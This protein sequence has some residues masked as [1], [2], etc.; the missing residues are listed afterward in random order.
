LKERSNTFSDQDVRV[1]AH[2]IW[3]RNG[4]PEDQAEYHWRDALAELEAE[5]LAKDG[6]V[7]ALFQ[8]S[9]LPIH[10]EAALLLVAPGRNAA[11]KRHA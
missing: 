5:E 11:N 6:R 1:R 9:S 8:V 7:P 10:S 2:Q 4:R 3:V